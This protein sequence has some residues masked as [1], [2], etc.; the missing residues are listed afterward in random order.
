MQTRRTSSL[1]GD[2]RSGKIGVPSRLF[3][4]G[5]AL[6][7]AAALVAVGPLRAAFTTLPGVLVVGASIL[8]MAPGALLT[9]WCLREYFS[10]AAL[11]PAAFVISAGT[12]AL[13]GVPMLV[14]RSSMGAYLWVSG[15]IVAASLLAAALA[16]LVGASRRERTAEAGTG[17]V[18]PDRGGLLWVP[19]VALVAA[20]TY[21]GR[22]N[23][24][25]FYGDIWIYLAW[26]REFLGGDGLASEEPYFGGEVGLSRVVINGWLLEQAAFS[27][28]SG[29]DPVE[30]V[31][32]YVNPALVVV[33]LLA[34]Y[35][36][37][38]TLFTSEKAAL[39]CGC[40][41]VLFFLVHLDASRLSF[42]GEFLQRLAEDKFAARFLFLPMALASAAAFLESG[43]RAYF[44]CFAFV[45]GAVLAV[46]PIGFAVIGVSMAGFGLLHLAVNPRSREAWARISAMGLAGLAVV[47]LPAIFVLAVLGEPLGAVLADSDINSGDPDVLR[48]MIFVQPGRERIFEFAD[49]SY[50]M[51]PSLVLNPVI[52]SGFVLGVPFLLWRLK[53]DLAAQLL[54]GAL[55]VSTAVCYVP[56]IATFVGDRV[57]LPGQLWR[58]AW[59]IPLAAL[60][61]LGWL[62]WET[63]SRAGAYLGGLRATRA[64]ARALPLLLVV[65]LTVAAV[66]RATAGIDLVERH[67]ATAR[68][69]GLYPA[70]PIY[71]W[72]RDEVTSPLVVLAKDLQGV[73][74]PAYSSEANVVSRRG[75]LVLQVLPRL[76]RRAPG[77]I[78]VPQ[79]SLDVREFFNRSTRERR[80]EILLRHEVDYVMVRSDSRLG[81]AIGELPGVKP[82]SEPSERYDLYR[83]NLRKLDRLTGG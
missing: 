26:I 42:G 81:P 23:A 7:G 37:A 38:R 40:L 82:A 61:T 45:C 62:A 1:R 25:S 8:F 83:V 4:A 47:G 71:P 52:L 50:I 12:F 13:V 32:S 27:R 69:L 3:E 22:I 16:A 20:L 58:L 53:R 75:S 29:V 49:G 72:F 80:V 6:A 2:R 68:S 70:D 44:W 30:L 33:A 51:H 74:I 35:A 39:L 15:A 73:R 67:K 17:F 43:R 41:Y 59:P 10:G 76:E 65:A 60:L 63:T 9:R 77:R 5:L 54:L 11:L 64:L 21:V 78:E 28:V 46:H 36:L 56:P 14:A 55:L 48:N 57:V 19:F 66:P 18:V 31:F 34:F 79:G 24:P